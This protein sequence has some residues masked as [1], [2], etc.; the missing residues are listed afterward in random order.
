MAQPFSIVLSS[1]EKNDISNA[2][3]IYSDYLLN[4]SINILAYVNDE[5]TIYTTKN[6]AENFPHLVGL[7]NI[8]RK[9]NATEIFNKALRVFSAIK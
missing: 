1:R 2:A 5:K 3:R 6:K 4:K 7:S 8:P 9:N